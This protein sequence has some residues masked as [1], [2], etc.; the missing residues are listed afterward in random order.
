LSGCPG[1]VV[2][3]GLGLQEGHITREAAE[4]LRKAEKVFYEGYT[5]FYYPDVAE[6]LERIGVER[7]RIVK[8]SRKDLEDR[9]GEALMREAAEG[10]TVAL[11]TVGD[12]FI[13]TT[14][15]ALR[16]SFLRMGCRVEY[17]PSV[18]VFSYSVSATGLFPYKFGESAT[19]VYP[20]DGIF[21]TYPYL[22]MAENLK[23]GLH[24]FFFL[25]IDERLGPLNAR[26]AVRL[27]IEAEERE[28]MG[29]FN[30]DREV[31]VIERA[32]WPDERIILA[33]ASAIMEKDL[34]PPHSL[35][36][37]GKLHF[38]ER[39]SIEVFRG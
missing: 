22:V 31:I 27:L 3:V 9:S 12:P 25:D 10:K 15:S 7:E 13:A 5:S 16:T 26:D 1:K 17:V 19:I 2:F 36:V 29:A 28:G 38:A 30:E 33:E 37:P 8:L 35:I 39:D 24:T 4:K 32:A 34:R 20:R 23:R 14:H 18:N 21:S 11:A 6:A